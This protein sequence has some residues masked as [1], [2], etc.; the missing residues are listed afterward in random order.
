MKTLKKSKAV[1]SPHHR[2]RA[3]RTAPVLL[4]AAALVAGLVFSGLSRLL[5]GSASAQERAQTRISES[6]MRQIEALMQEKESRTPEQKKIDSQLLYRLKQR[7]GEQIAPGVE[8]L[9]V[10]V[11]EAADGSVLLD[12]RAKVTP[13][14]LEAIRKAG[15]EV[16]SA[17][18]QFD[19]IRA[20]LTLDTLEK[21]AGLDE[22]K[23]IRPADEGMTNGNSDRRS[24]NGQ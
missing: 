11:K 17:H 19:A 22:V 18:E 16:I 15:G 8:R 20:R 7:R 12:I 1:T 24:V 13:E 23:F 21:L 6:A 14:V 9:V 4:I 3:L 2:R 5:R 10:G